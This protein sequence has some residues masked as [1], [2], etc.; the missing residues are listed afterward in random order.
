[1]ESV[2]WRVDGKERDPDE[3]VPTEGDA[4]G[5]QLLVPRSVTVTEGAAEARPD[6]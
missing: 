3:S 2:A 4:P 6:N 1:V 5:V